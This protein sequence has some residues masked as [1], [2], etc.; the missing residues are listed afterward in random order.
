[1]PIPTLENRC[2]SLV[3]SCSRRLS[4]LLMY[5]MSDLFI[6]VI[7]LDP[8]DFFPAHKGH[9]RSHD[10]RCGRY[11]FELSTHDITKEVI[12][13]VN[14]CRCLEYVEG[15]LLDSL[16]ALQSLRSLGSVVIVP[17]FLVLSAIH[18]HFEIVALR[19]V[20]IAGDC[21]IFPDTLFSNTPNGCDGFLSGS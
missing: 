11:P 8:D 19:N 3:S 5:S 4:R 16:E 9:R 2:S 13:T 20:V 10:L 14:A 12:P 18:I 7:H 15:E 6:A 17:T 21:E 1:M